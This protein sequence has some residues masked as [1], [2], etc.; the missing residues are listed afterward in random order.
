MVT[1]TTSP[2]G[3]TPQ[4]PARAMPVTVEHPTVVPRPD[5]TVD[6]RAT[7]ATLGYGSDVVVPQSVSGRIRSRPL[8]FGVVSVLLVVGACGSSDDTKADA[9]VRDPG[10]K[11]EL[12]PDTPDAASQPDPAGGTA[13]MT[14]AD[15]TQYEYELATCVTSDMEQQGVAAGTG[16]VVVGKTADGTSSLALERV[17]VSDDESVETGGI[18]VGLERTGA[19]TGFYYDAGFESLQTLV[20]NGTK[21]SG[22]LSFQVFGL[23]GPHGS[24][25]TATVDVRC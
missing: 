7:E 23:P 9:A 5:A 18:E 20:V 6:S 24:E 8:V 3:Y 10:S 13:T 11:T 14:I 1:D 25:T 16:Y 4:P 12:T 22:E 19:T 2:V 21:V 15:G 17:W